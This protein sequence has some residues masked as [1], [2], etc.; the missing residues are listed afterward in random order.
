DFR[1]R[2]RLT[3]VFGP[4]T[5][6]CNQTALEFDR[7]NHLRRGMDLKESQ[8]SSRTGLLLIAVSVGLDRAQTATETCSVLRVT[9]PSTWDCTS[10]S[11]CPGK[12][13]HCSSVGKFSTSP[14]RSGLM[15]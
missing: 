7:L 5:G 14:T 11:S 9:S 13:M 1:S 15:V 4:R 10:R 3:A 12:V 8:M 2:H 6:T